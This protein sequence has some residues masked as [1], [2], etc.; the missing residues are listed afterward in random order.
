MNEAKIEAKIVAMFLEDIHNDILLM[1]VNLRE[2]EQTLNKIDSLD[3][4]N[5]LEGYLKAT[6]KQHKSINEAFQTS[7]MVGILEKYNK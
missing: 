6:K 5:K 3:D 7:I 1:E 4:L 2:V